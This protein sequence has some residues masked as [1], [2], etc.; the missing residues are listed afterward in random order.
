MFYVL[1]YFTGVREAN[2][3]LEAATN[4]RASVEGVSTRAHVR[5]NSRTQ[6]LS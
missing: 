5:I 4:H 6:S 1:F 2:Y 3:A